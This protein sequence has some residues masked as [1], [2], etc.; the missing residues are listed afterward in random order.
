MSDAQLASLMRSD[1]RWAQSAGQN[2]ATPDDDTYQSTQQAGAPYTVTQLQAV[3]PTQD[4]GSVITLTATVTSTASPAPDGTLVTF[5]TDLGA[6]STR[7]VVNGG[8]ALAHITSDVTGTAH[9]SATTRGAGGAIQHTLSVTFTA[10]SPGQ[11]P[12][13]AVSINGPTTG[14]VAAAYTFAATVTPISVTL[15]LTYV[16]QATNHTPVTHTGVVSLTDVCSF[17]WAVTGTQ[18]IT[19]TATN[20]LASRSDTHTIAIRQEQ[21]IYLPLVLRSYVATQGQQKSHCSVSVAR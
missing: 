6:I 19:V 7:A 12:P 11:V 16:W 5:A 14:V 15:P 13:E 9:I 3:P 1:Y 18:S 2:T 4:V 8:V 17:T 21:F 20:H 10:P